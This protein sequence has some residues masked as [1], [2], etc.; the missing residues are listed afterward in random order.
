MFVLGLIA[1][2]IF[3][4]CKKHKVLHGVLKKYLAMCDIEP[5]VFN[6]AHK[7]FQRYNESTCSNSELFDESTQVD[8]LVSR[9]CS[10]IID[11]DRQ[12]KVV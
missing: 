6:N 5:S 10:D 12:N 2:C 11:F 7:I 4:A 8:D 1:C 3:Y 9:F